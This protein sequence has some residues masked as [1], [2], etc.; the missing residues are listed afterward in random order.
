MTRE[1]REGA[2]ERALFNAKASIAA[3]LRKNWRG[4]GAIAA[5]N[6]EQARRWMRYAA[7]SSNPATRRAALELQ[8]KVLD[9][10]CFTPR[11]RLDEQG[12]P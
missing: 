9:G 1:E 12:A 3:H 8:K 6:D 2:C 11:R 5:F 10:C 4:R 7:S